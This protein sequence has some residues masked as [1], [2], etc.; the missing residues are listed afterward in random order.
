M[1]DVPDNIVT[2]TDLKRWPYLPKVC[3]PNIKANVDP[4]I[5]TSAPRLLEPWEVVTALKMA[6][7]L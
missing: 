6:H 4:V 1:P 5:G 7:K 2:A 3:V